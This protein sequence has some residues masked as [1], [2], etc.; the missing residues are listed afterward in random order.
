VFFTF[1]DAACATP[2]VIFP[3]AGTPGA[4]PSPRRRVWVSAL[5]SSPS[6]PSE[7]VPVC[8]MAKEMSMVLADSTQGSSPSAALASTSRI[9]AIADPARSR[10]CR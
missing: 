3:D 10:R 8:V 6:A 7:M 9:V 4:G 5:A 2:A 1:P